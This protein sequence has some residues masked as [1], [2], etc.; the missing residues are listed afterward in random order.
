M[1]YRSFSTE[2]WQDPW[3]EQLSVKS[4]LL[5]IYLWTNDVCN[6]AGCYQ[7]SS[8]RA[9][10]ETSIKLQDTIKELIP[11]VEWFQ[12]QQVVWVKSFFKRQCANEKFALS[13]IRSL[14][15][16]PKKIAE[17]WGIHNV[18]I[19]EKYG[20]D[21]V[22]I[23]YACHIDTLCVSVT[24]TDTDTVPG[25]GPVPGTRLRQEEGFQDFWKSYPK[26]IGKQE[27]KREWI[28]QNGNRPDLFSVISKIEDLKKSDQWKKDG[29]QYIPHPA[30]WLNRGGWD[31]EVKIDVK[32][33]S[34]KPWLEEY[35]YKDTN[36]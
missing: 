18:S 6:Q 2:T 17:L 11:K 4:K 10:F 19:L 34:D 8:R 30:T 9:E 33:Q 31:D 35:G 16:I 29:G 25:T 15:C 26:K 20:I 28:K 3:F 5:F 24:D 22:S 1:A 13:A 14:Y 23:P 27:A 12:E 21:T 7:I 32:K 36:S